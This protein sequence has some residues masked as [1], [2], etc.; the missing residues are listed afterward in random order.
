MYRRVNSDRFMVLTT[1]GIVVVMAIFTWVMYGMAQQVFTITD[2][3]VD[4][5]KSFQVMTVDI[6]TM[7]QNIEEMSANV[8]SMSVDMN[9]MSSNISGITDDI[10]TMAD[11]VPAMTNAM[12]SMAAGVDRMVQDMA[13]ATYAFTQPMSYMWGNAFPF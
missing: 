6:H 3:M 2:V 10:E 4:L 13:R 9:N 7:G 12:L 1:L 8:L 5:N 11:S